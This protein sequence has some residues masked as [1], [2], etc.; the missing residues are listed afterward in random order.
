MSKPIINKKKFETMT[1][2]I[3]AQ[4]RAATSEIRISEKLDFKIFDYR[5]FKGEG[6]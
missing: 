4:E 6:G 5:G 2:G 1:P 3:C